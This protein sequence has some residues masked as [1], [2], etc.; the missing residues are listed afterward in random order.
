[1]KVLQDVRG[2]GLRGGRAGMIDCRGSEGTGAHCQ[3]G[4]EGEFQKER[5][6]QLAQC[7]R[8]GCKTKAGV[9]PLVECLG[10]QLGSHWPLCKDRYRRTR[11]V[12]SSYV[13]WDWRAS[14]LQGLNL[15]KS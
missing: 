13:C 15:F 4:C 12:G 3:G 7:S 14:R 8:I 2:R 9:W 5:V 6:I 1:M 11:G 10:R